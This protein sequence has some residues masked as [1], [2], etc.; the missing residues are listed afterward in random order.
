MKTYV[1]KVTP[2]AKPRMT[3]GDR[4]NYRPVTQHYWAY[5]NELKALA[6]IEGLA[7]LPGSI[8]RIV[9]Y[10]P[11]PGSW[12]AKK[13][14]KMNHQPHQQRPDLSN[15]L[16]GLEDILCTEDSHI[17][18]FRDGLV[19]LWGYEGSIHLFLTFPSS[20]ECGSLS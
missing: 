5:A 10:L 2:I 14:E 19:K 18:E 9:F 7:T 16:K 15:L 8:D 6:N 4:A 1:F 13:K 17:Y 20:E 11:M 3:K 12:S